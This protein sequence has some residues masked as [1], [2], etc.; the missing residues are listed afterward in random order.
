MGGTFKSKTFL[1]ET[2]FT[3]GLDSKN[4]FAARSAQEAGGQERKYSFSSSEDPL[5]GNN[6]DLPKAFLGLWAT[7]QRYPEWFEK[8]ACLQDRLLDP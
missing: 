3:K 4:S 8:D 6:N 5:L 7:G 1:V 2:L